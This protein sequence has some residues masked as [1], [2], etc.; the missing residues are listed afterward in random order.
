MGRSGLK[1]LTP[2][3]KVEA[4]ESP[5]KGFGVFAIEDIREGEVIEDCVLKPLGGELSASN[6]FSDY[7][8]N[9]PKNTGS[10]LRVVALGL[11]SVFNHTENNNADWINHPEL[12]NVFRYVANRPIKA[13]E[14]VCIYYGDVNY[15]EGQSVKPI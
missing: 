1:E 5:G 13:G 4:R 7:R 10:K 3:R 9:Y 11:G 15:W 12:K 14:E 8:Y 6:I 2:P